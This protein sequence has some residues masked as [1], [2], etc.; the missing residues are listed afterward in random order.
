MVALGRCYYIKAASTRIRS[1]I[2]FMETA[3]FSLRFHL[4]ST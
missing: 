4:A 1:R 3:N 2:V